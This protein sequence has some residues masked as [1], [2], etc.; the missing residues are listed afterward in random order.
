MAKKYRNLEVTLGIV[1]SELVHD[2][3][4]VPKTLKR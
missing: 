3:D 1:W 4:E 2:R